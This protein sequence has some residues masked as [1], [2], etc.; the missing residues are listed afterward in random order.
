MEVEMNVQMNVQ[1]NTAWP[2]AGLPVLHKGRH[3]NPEEGACLMEYVSI[4]A[5]EPFSDRPAC[6]DPLLARL[7]WAV[8]DAAEDEV[9]AHLPGLAPRFIGTAT[10]DPLVA[11]SIVVACCRYRGLN[12]SGSPG[13]LA[14]AQ[15]R[16]ETR[17]QRLRAQPE[18]RRRFSDRLYRMHADMPVQEAVRLAR[19]ADATA[20]PLLLAAALDAVTGVV[21]EVATRRSAP[22][23][24]VV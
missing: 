9:R 15:H 3:A 11:P 10:S 22:T 24:T 7:A 13:M 2:P 4:L 8:N 19:M 21:G 5:G 20:L 6:V 12:G 1:M 17:L 23:T 18:R 14:R 16:A